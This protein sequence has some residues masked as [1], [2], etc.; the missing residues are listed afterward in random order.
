MFDESNDQIVFIAKHKDWISIKKLLI[1][2]HVKSEDISLQLA[3]V[4]KAIGEKSFRYAEIDTAKVDEVAQK[5]A[6]GKKKNFASLTEAFGSL[7]SSELKKELESACKTP[8]HYPLAEGYFLKA[9]IEKIGYYTYPDVDILQ[10]VYPELKIPKPRG[11][12]GK[13]KK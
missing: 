11:N 5:Y 10:K 3:L 12:F 9:L 6:A 13:K 4:Q 2:E 1:D 8:A 7:K